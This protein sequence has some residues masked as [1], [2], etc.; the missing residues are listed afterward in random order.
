MAAKNSEMTSHMKKELARCRKACEAG[1]LPALYDA[2]VLCRRFDHSPEDWMMGQLEIIMEH[3][4]SGRLTTPRRQYVPKISKYRNHM[5][6]YVRWD[7]VIE[8]REKQAEFRKDLEH[9]K[10]IKNVRKNLRED[11]EKQYKAIG[12]TWVQDFE[13]ASRMLRGTYARGSAE[14][15]RKSYYLVQRQMA[16]KAKLSRPYKYY[17]ASNQAFAL[18]GLKSGETSPDWKLV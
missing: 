5:K 18:M 8:I 16:G 3:I 10:K 6:H 12:K 2:I 4:L 13:V 9:L 7:A 14:T 1:A 11:L 15:F 17:V